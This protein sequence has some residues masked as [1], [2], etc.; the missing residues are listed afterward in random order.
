MTKEQVLAMLPEFSNALTAEERDLFL[1]NLYVRSLKKNELIY[2][3]GEIPSKLFCLLSG[4][5]KIYKDGVGGRSQIVRVM[6]AVEFFGYRASFSGEPFITAAAAFEPS[7]IACVPLTLVK[8]LILQ[9]A[10]VAW[11]F[12]HQLASLLG[13]SDERLVNLTQKHIRGRLA[14]SILFMKENYGV[15]ADGDTLAIHLSREDMAN[16]SNMTTSNAIR[17]LNSFAREGLIELNGRRIRIV[18]EDELRRVSRLG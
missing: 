5:V 13:K 3:E 6:H 14:E 7:V 18:R 12:I 2:H 17:T 11:L 15:E 9:N 16:L 8:K 4:K 1:D 10:R